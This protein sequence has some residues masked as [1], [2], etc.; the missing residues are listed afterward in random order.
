VVLRGGTGRQHRVGVG[1]RP[2]RAGPVRRVVVPPQLL[3]SSR[4]DGDRAPALPL[5]PLPMGAAPL[6][7]PRGRGGLRGVRLPQRQPRGHAGRGDPA[8]ADPDRRPLRRVRVPVGAP[9]GPD[10]GRAPVPHRHLRRGVVPGPARRRLE[11]LAERPG[12]GAGRRSGLGP[13]LGEPDQGQRARRP[14]RH[15]QQPARGR[16]GDRRLRPGGVP[17]R[18]LTFAR[19]LLGLGEHRRLC[20]TVWAYVGFGATI[21]SLYDRSIWGPVALSVIAIV[22]A[23]S[24]SDGGQRPAPAADSDDLLVTSR[25]GRR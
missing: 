3:R 15:P 11:L 25:E 19:P 18:L 13:V 8:A 10:G 22:G 1:G 21:P 7:R 5:L 12:P 6:S 2:V 16:G 4:D 9:R 23:N 17:A 20:Y 14:L 24:T